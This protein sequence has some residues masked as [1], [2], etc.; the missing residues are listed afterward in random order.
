MFTILLI[1]DDKGYSE[2]LVDLASNHDMVIRWISNL[3]DAMIELQ[4]QFEQYDGVILDGRGML[5]A[6]EDQEKDSHLF[7]AIRKLDGLKSHGKY[8][9]AVVNTGFIDRYKTSFETE[10]LKIFSKN[11]EESSMLRH[12]KSLIAG[13]DD[14]K[15]RGKYPDAFAAF[16]DGYIDKSKERYLLDVL[17]VIENQ[18]FSGLEEHFATPLRKVLEAVY[19][20]IN[21]MDSA[22]LPNDFIP[23]GALNLT[24]CQ[25]YLSG[26]AVNSMD[27]RN[28]IKR[29][30]RHDSLWPT[31]IGWL[32]TGVQGASQNL[33]HDSMDYPPR[34]A[35]QSIA[36]G[37]MELLVW[38]KSFVDKRNYYE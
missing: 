33:S 32:T 28:V 1:D 14:E 22:W 18:D 29:Y 20:R 17:K 6:E 16:G 37:I 11:G 34:Y 13:S 25:K 26:L 30:G 7:Q 24:N 21:E 35:V 5:N 4:N 8:I 12:L 10:D 23:N 3:E 27:G 9:P 19:R 31:R 38:F 15:I 36:F 2:T